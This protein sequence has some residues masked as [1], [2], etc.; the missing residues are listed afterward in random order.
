MDWI[1]DLDKNRIP[2]HI[3]IIMDG[4][5]RWAKSKG[6][7]R[8]F[9]HKQGVNAVREVTEGGAEIGLKYLTLYAFSTENW[10]RP[11]LEINALMSLL[12]S[13]MDKEID[14]LLKNNI[15]L[16]TIGDI[17]KLPTANYNSLQNGIEKTRQNTGMNL[18]LALNYSGRWDLV[19]ALRTFYDKIKSGEIEDA[20][21]ND[22]TFAGLLSTADVPDPGLLIRTSGELRLSN[23]LLW[24]MAYT[25]LYFTDVMW[26]DFTKNELYLALKNYQSRERRFGKISEQI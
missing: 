6:K 20:S 24:E 12:V 15:R 22:D 18:I 13:T 1:R 11:K 17:T 7:P 8:V 19:H 21:I 2:E 25:E 10:N 4:N 26:P 5:G 14:T 16:T 9:G 3:A 23:F